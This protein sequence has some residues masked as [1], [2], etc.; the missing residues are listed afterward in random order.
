MLVTD[1]VN[2]SVWV[3]HV[4]DN[5]AVLH[6]VEVLSHHHVFIAWQS[7]R[8]G[9]IKDKCRKSSETAKNKNDKKGKLQSV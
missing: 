1:H 5:A 2:L 4:A 9:E 3:S 6:A 8:D 7:E